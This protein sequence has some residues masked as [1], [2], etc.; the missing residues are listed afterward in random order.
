[1]DAYHSGHMDYSM[2]GYGGEYGVGGDGL[3][4]AQHSHEY[5]AAAA[6]GMDPAAMAL[7]GGDA[8]AAYGAAHYGGMAYDPA[9]AAAT[10][11]VDFSGYG[12]YQ[13]QEQQPAAPKQPLP[14]QK[15]NRAGTGGGGAAGGSEAS[16][17][18]PRSKRP[19]PGQF[20]DDLEEDADEVGG[21]V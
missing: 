1:M 14:G 7:Y 10:A 13:Q 6:A 16:P 5:A 20:R 11:S 19:R 3:H 17:L 12:Y 2:A 21:A 8:A 18:G 4:Y 15:R 9:A